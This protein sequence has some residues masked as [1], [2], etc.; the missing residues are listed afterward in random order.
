MV[1]SAIPGGFE[2]QQVIVKG[3]DDI[4]HGDQHQDQVTLLHGGHKNDQFA[5]K[6]DGGW[7][8]F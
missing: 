1:R 8:A 5:C 3:D 7:D 6:P 2:H 4:G